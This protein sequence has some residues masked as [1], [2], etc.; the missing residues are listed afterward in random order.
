MLPPPC[1][2][3]LHEVNAM[4]TFAKKKNWEFCLVGVGWKE[5]VGVQVVMWG[6][7]GAGGTQVSRAVRDPRACGPYP[8]PLPSSDPLVVLNP[9]ST[10]LS[11]GRVSVASAKPPAPTP[12]SPPPNSSRDASPTTTKIFTAAEQPTPIF[13]YLPPPPHTFYPQPAN[14]EVTHFDVMVSEVCGHGP[15]ARRRCRHSHH[16]HHT[17]TPRSLCRCYVCICVTSGVAAPPSVAWRGA[18]TPPS[19][20]FHKTHKRRLWYSLQCACFGVRSTQARLLN[21]GPLV[22]PYRVQNRVSLGEEGCRPVLAAGPESSTGLKVTVWTR[23][24]PRSPHGP[25]GGRALERREGEIPVYWAEALTGGAC[26]RQQ[27]SERGR[28]SGSCTWSSIGRVEKLLALLPHLR[29]F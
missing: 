11:S 25:K 23:R 12:A 26:L 2:L 3:E 13:S 22:V 1:S 28:A 29:K 16:H 18:A 15:P 4:A 17:A 7:G 6:K 9:A 24:W 27:E 19:Y 14:L 21:T 20:I 8:L 5:C 10:L